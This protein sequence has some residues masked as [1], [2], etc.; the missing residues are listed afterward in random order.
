MRLI[1]AIFVALPVLALS[2]APVKDAAACGGCFPTIQQMES[3]Q[4]SGHRM[5]L[6][7][8]TT[9]TTLWDQITYVGSPESFAWVLPIKG[10]VKVGVSSD[11]LFSTLE[12]HTK[13]TVNSPR[14][15]CPPPPFCAYSGGNGAG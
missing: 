11:A 10:E 4:V 14:I 12:E 5:I 6:S 8:G 2:L 13:V 1:Q 9:Q 7:I 3:T 15:S